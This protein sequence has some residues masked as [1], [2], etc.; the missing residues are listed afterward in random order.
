MLLSAISLIAYGGVDLCQ[1]M[2][3]SKTDAINHDL[4]WMIS[5]ILMHVDIVYLVHYGI[6]VR[7]NINAVNPLLGSTMAPATLPCTRLLHPILW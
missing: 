2:D 1:L 4:K 3:H 7:P 5:F 6:V